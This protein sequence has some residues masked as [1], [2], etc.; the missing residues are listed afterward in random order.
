MKITIKNDATFA[1]DHPIPAG[2]YIVALA[3]DGAHLNLSG[4]GK[5][6]SVPAIRRRRVAH[7][8]TA[9][10]SFFSGGGRTWSL[11]FVSPKLG[12][13]VAFIDV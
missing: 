10:V 11:V 5:T 8:K 13:F 9:Q 2:E 4:G 3:S 6:F 1:G 7:T 12:E